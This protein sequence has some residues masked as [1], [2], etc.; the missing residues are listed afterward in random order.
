[1]SFNAAD[2]CCFVCGRDA[3]RHVFHV[4]GKKVVDCPPGK[5]NGEMAEPVERGIEEGSEAGGMTAVTGNHAL[6]NIRS[7]S[8]R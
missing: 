8:D 6:E 1:M 2:K 5:V 4:A 7:A 3:W